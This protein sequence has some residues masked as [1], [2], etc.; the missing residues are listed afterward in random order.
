MTLSA[1]VVV[2][3]MSEG[4]C[5]LSIEFLHYLFAA[6]EYVGTKPMSWGGQ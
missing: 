3:P 6:Y 4:I 2:R 5:S 1:S